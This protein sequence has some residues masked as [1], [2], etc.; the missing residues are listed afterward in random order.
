[1]VLFFVMS[2]N[3]NSPISMS[4]FNN[5]RVAENSKHVFVYL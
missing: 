5:F 2:H 4:D 3:S 1:M